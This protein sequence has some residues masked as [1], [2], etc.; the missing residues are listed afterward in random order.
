MYKLRGGSSVILH[1][2]RYLNEEGV[3][4]VVLLFGFC[5]NGAVMY[6][7]KDTKSSE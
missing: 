2:A 1:F 3:T 5:E 7:H 4:V 6:K